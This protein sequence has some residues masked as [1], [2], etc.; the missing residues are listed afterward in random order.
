MENFKASKWTSIKSGMASQILKQEYQADSPSEEK[1]NNT[2]RGEY[3]ERL[4]ARQALKAFYGIKERQFK[5]TFRKSNFDR[6]RSSKSFLGLLERR[7]DIILVR[8]GLAK[9]IFQAKQRILHGFF[10]VNNRRVKSP[11]YKI[12]DGEIL[13]IHEKHWKRIYTE[14]VDRLKDHE[15][16]RYPPDYLLIDFYT[17]NVIFLREPTINEVVYPWNANIK[18]I[19]EN[20]R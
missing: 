15:D 20:Y 11:S 16:F 1:G 18:L 19:R 9:T 13:Q 17:L 10:L 2:L 6:R 7:L 4:K 8:T 5:K 12:R 14:V 3:G